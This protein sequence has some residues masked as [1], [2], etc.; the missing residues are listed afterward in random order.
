M[1]CKN[2]RNAIRK[3]GIG[4]RIRIR[5]RMY[6]M[7]RARIYMQ[8]HIFVCLYYFEERRSK[9]NTHTFWRRQQALDLDGFYSAYYFTPL[10]VH[11]CIAYFDFLVHIVCAASDSRL[12]D[13]SEWV[14]YVCARFYAC[15]AAASYITYIV[16]LYSS[17]CSC[18]A[19]G[20]T[21]H[22]RA[23]IDRSRLSMNWASL[24]YTKIT[25]SN[26]IM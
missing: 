13:V 8:M 15:A 16:V 14:K 24:S 10:L 18:A 20:C 4:I 17:A 25:A 3:A 19:L 11:A 1:Y 22:M 2:C 26:Q 23:L 6:V 7:S 12:S 21:L 9:K 5:I